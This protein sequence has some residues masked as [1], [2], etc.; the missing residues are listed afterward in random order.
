MKKY[1]L[2]TRCGI[3]R[4]RGSFLMGSP[5]TER[6]LVRV[7]KRKMVHLSSSLEL[8]GS[9]GY[10]SRSAG[11]ILSTLIQISVDRSRK[12]VTTLEL[13]PVEGVE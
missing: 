8:D 4:E 7:L 5:S 13:F 2:L 12:K 10:L 11:C 3:E 1:L 6:I 9:V